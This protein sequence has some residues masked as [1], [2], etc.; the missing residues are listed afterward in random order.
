MVGG[1]SRAH[2]DVLRAKPSND[3]PCR[4]EVRVGSKAGARSRIA[5]EETLPRQLDRSR[6]Y[7]S[8]VSGQVSEMTLQAQRPGLQVP[9]AKARIDRGDGQ[10]S[11]LVVRRE[12]CQILLIALQIHHCI[13]GNGLR[14]VGKNV[15]SAGRVGERQFVR[16]DLKAIVNGRRGS[17][18]QAW[19]DG[20]GGRARELVILVKVR[21]DSGYRTT[22]TD[23]DLVAGQPIQL[24]PGSKPVFVEPVTRLRIDHELLRDPVRSRRKS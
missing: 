12:R 22:G 20:K 2:Q 8:R 10:R 23:M 24:N 18:S 13:A 1:V 4:V 19:V 7:I 6:S 17:R 5:V 11:D 21:R 14:S 9:I 15:R 3:V 16:S